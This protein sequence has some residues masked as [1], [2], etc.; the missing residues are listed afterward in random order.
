MTDFKKIILSFVESIKY[1]KR[2]I[3]SF[4][5]RKII[6]YYFRQFELI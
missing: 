5:I 1:K 6:L 2:E 3:N 4:I